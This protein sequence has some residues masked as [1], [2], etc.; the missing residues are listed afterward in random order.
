MTLNVCPLDDVSLIRRFIVVSLV[1]VSPSVL[2]VNPRMVT[3][4]LK[5]EEF[6]EEPSHTYVLCYV[7]RSETSYEA[8]LE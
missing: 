6:D 7:E 3:G 2:T 8:P 1:T 5:V 4:V